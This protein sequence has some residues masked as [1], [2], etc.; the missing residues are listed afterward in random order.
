MHAAVGVA[1]SY[2]VVSSF[3]RAPICMV[4]VNSAPGR[5][6]GMIRMCFFFLSKLLQLQNF[7][8]TLVWF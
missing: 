2:S 5:T 7:S 1:C 6:L 8:A 4:S 3:A